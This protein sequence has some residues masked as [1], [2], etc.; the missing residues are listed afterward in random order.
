[1]CACVRACVCACM[2]ACVRVCV[3]VCMCVCVLQAAIRNVL[4]IQ[5]TICRI[6]IASNRTGT[7]AVVNGSTYLE[8]VQVDQSTQRCQ[9]VVFKVHAG[10]RDKD[11]P[12][13]HSDMVREGLIQL[14]SL[15][16]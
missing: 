4:L 8:A 7:M 16:K 10:M 3:C 11:Q 9:R 6:S 13:S 12:F 2:R 1:M 5:K 14:E 15:T